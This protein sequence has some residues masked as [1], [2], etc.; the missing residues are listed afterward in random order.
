[1]YDYYYQAALVSVN[2]TVGVDSHNRMADRV[3]FCSVSRV[4]YATPCTAKAGEM[5]TW[6]IPT[7]REDAYIGVTFSYGNEHIV[8]VVA[9][10][11]LVDTEYS[12][13]EALSLYGFGLEK[14]SGR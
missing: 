5:E 10:L 1:M 13:E 6:F 12:L 4:T 8:S 9:S 7:N 3:A 2:S 11:V 14:L